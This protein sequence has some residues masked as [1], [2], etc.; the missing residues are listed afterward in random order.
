MVGTAEY[1]VALYFLM[2]PQNALALNLEGITTVP[3]VERVERVA[4][5]EKE[6]EE[7][8][9]VKLDERRRRH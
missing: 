1:H 2:R 3:P 4:P 6:E 7:E 5:E 9:K 8:K